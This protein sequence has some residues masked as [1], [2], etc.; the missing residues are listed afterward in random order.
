MIPFDSEKDSVI[1]YYGKTLKFQFITEN[2]DFVTHLKD[3]KLDIS[4]DVYGYVNVNKK[5]FHRTVLG[6][7]KGQHAQKACHGPGGHLDNRKRTL[8]IDTHAGNMRDMS[9]KKT[10]SASLERGVSWQGGSNQSWRVRIRIKRIECIC[11]YT[12]S[13]DEAVHISKLIYVMASDLEKL[14]HEC[15]KA[16]ILKAIGP[17]TSYKCCGN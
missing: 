16:A 6:L 2:E 17:K 4:K 5:G 15:V 7:N 11:R 10:T 12:K 8:R 9:R 3:K 13:H 1:E 14:D